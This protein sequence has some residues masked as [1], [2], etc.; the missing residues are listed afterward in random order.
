MIKLNRD[1]KSLLLNTYV[2]KAL[3][4][5]GSCIHFPDFEGV[6]DVK[7]G[8]RYH[9]TRHEHAAIVIMDDFH[10]VVLDER[11]YMQT[12]ET[13]HRWLHHFESDVNM[14]TGQ[15]VVINVTVVQGP[16]PTDHYQ[17]VP[18]EDAVQELEEETAEEE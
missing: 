3:S 17:E 4:D 18:V 9:D 15:S 6:M 7:V 11:L 8:Y 10:T 14:I 12:R 1:D 5:G 2:K 13:F 16:I